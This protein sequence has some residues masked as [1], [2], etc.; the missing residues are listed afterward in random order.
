MLEASATYRDVRLAGGTHGGNVA[1]LGKPV[2]HQLSIALAARPAALPHSRR[3]ARGMLEAQRC[4]TR[5]GLRGRKAQAA[6]YEADL[7][8]D[9][10]P[11][12]RLQVGGV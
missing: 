11:L 12:V 1:R 2:E 5:E 6:R 10:Q 4:L 9:E 3:D 7:A 8:R